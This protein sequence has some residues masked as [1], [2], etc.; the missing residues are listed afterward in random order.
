VA[1]VDVLVVGSGLAG[2]TAARD[3]K[4]QGRSVLLLEAR[5]RIGGRTYTRP[6]AGHEDLT[7]E[8]GGA[9]LNL[10]GER[11][12]R[13][14]IER[15]GIEVRSPEG[16][17]EQGRFVV[18]GRLSCGL[19][20][21]LD[22][23][24]AIE[25]TM[26]RLTQDVGRLSATIPL[27]EQ[28]VADLDISVGEYIDRLGLP[29][30]AHDFVTGA[31]AGWIQCDPAR[32]SILQILTSVLSCGGSPVDT[33][34]GTF[35]ETFAH[36]VRDLLEAMVA[37][38]GIDVRLGSHVVQVTQED[39]QVRLTTQAAEEHT[40]AACVVAVPAWTLGAVEFSP[41]LDADKQQIL[42]QEHHVRGVKKILLVEGAPRGVFGVGGRS[43]RAQWLMEDR[44][45]PDGRVVLV[46][47]CIDP[48]LASNDLATAQAIVEE[49]V[50]E[51]TVLAVD[52]EDWYGDPLT[53]GIVGFCPTG[54]AQAFAEVMARPQ[55]RVAFAGA[56]LTTAPTFWGWMEGAVESGHTAAQQVAG[57]LVGSG[58]E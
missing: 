33:F 43:A 4:D 48:S 35:G 29:P 20:V 51:A 11:N 21:P 15:Y 23:L 57:L 30:E 39:S 41:P 38:S 56:E 13:R 17:V 27:T 36:G 22:Q 58:R 5:D 26:V 1:H 32:T 8:A 9:Y 24:G 50:P 3:L 7:I 46:A 40:A 31:I 12:L 14:E 2:L 28:P 6:F 52:G 47:F 49:F 18:G 53:R 34:F 54:Q 16:R 42:Q 37:G 55:G 25:R 10:R 45:L 44:V 19:P